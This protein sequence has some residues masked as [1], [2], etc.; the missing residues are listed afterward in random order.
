MK[1]VAFYECFQYR[2]NDFDRAVPIVRNPHERGISCP[3]D[4]NTAATRMF[5]Y[6]DADHS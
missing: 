6:S 2:A 4:V 1:K 3:R 5:L